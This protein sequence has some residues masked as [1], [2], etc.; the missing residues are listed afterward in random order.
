M[1]LVPGTENLPAT[2]GLVARV[3]SSAGARVLAGRPAGA[4]DAVSETK[5][6]GGDWVTEFDRGAERAVRE[7][8]GSMRPADVLTGEEY[9]AST[10][11]DASGYRWSIDPLDGTAN[12]VRGIVYYAT[13]VGVC[14]P[15]PDGTEV[16]LAGA[17]TAPAL[18]CQYFAARG[19]GAYKVGWNPETG[20][21][22][23]EPVRLHGPQGGR[24]DAILATGFGYDPAVRQEQ[25]AALAR[26]LP[27]FANVRRLG[28]AALDLC[29][30]AEG[31][32]DAYA[33]RGIR[34]WDYAAGALIAAEA[35]VPVVRPA[36][37]G[38]WQ[39]AGRLPVDPSQG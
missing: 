17:V 4:L 35:G 16:W 8:L 25:A 13:S 18:R 14:G 19:E 28:S 15:G 36:F 34:E 11:E 12:F 29:L 5:S 2:L 26:M 20:E 33:E 32:L 23:G 6:A 21:A 37:D 39:L 10:P 7:L 1:K 9:A 22:E 24:A 27:G 30:V 38:D 31:V 3:A